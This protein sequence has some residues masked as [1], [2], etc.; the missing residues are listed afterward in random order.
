MK[1]ADIAVGEW[2]HVASTWSRENRIGK[3]YINGIQTGQQGVTDPTKSLDLNPT[4]HKVFDIGLKRDAGNTLDG[5]L[6]DLIVI[7]K[8]IS[9]QELKVLVDSNRR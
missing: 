8:A 2:M 3:L 4:G 6:R 9:D 7:G 1:R 5:Y